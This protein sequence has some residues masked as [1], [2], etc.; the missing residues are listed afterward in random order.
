MP[1]DRGGVHN[2]L[3][4]LGVGPNK[5]KLERVAR[6]IADTF[7]ECSPDV[8]C[9]CLAWVEG[10]D[11]RRVSVGLSWS[12]SAGT[13]PLASPFRPSSGAAAARFAPF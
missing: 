12:T 4:A 8:G 7:I 9:L 5:K 13:G 1:Y 6:M 2:G 3:K 10:R 11:L